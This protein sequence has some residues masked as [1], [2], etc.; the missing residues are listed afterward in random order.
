M[1]DTDLL[2]TDQVNKAA[3]AFSKSIKYFKA[4]VA[5]LPAKSVR[6]VFSAIGEFPLAVKDPVF[7]NKEEHELF[8]LTLQLI[9]AKNI[10]MDAVTRNKAQLEQQEKKEVEDVGQQ[11]GMA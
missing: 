5:M 2:N 11:T 8:V 9:A 4:R 1:S 3:E 7:R 10:M 6:R